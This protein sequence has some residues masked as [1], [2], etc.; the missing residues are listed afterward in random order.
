MKPRLLIIV[1]SDPRTSP[2]PAEAVRIA[3]GVGAWDRLELI[4]YLH[5]PAVHLLTSEREEYPDGENY[6]RYLPLVR[7]MGHALRH[8]GD[9]ELLASENA[10]G[11]VPIDAVELARLAAGCSSVLRF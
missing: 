10:D 1:D 3:A 4:L 7:E 8:Q 5:G 2:R 11:S 6:D 9:A